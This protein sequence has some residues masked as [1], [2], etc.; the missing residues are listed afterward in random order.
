MCEWANDP[1]KKALFALQG[2]AGLRVS[3][4]RSITSDSIDVQ[5]MMLR[6]RGKGDKTRL[7]P[8]S[9]S[10]WPYIAEAFLISQETGSPIV[11]LS[12]RGA[13]KAVTA[14]GRALGFKRE[15][16]SHDLRATGATHLYDKTKDIRVVQEFLGHSSSVTTQLYTGV[17][18]DS[19]RKGLEF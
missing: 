17:S 11:N 3:E 10:A 13:R 12:D 19:M 4:A 5:D 6:V 8:I 15:I 1:N 18:M 7:V 2:M 14:A 9:K 16:A